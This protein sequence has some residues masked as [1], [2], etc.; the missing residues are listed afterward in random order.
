MDLGAAY[1]EGM[2]IPGR[3][4]NGVVVLEGGQSLPEGASV[5]VTVCNSEGS[6]EAKDLP[7]PFPIVRS[8][9]P[10]SVKLT[11]D[12]IAELLEDDDLSSGR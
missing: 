3:V 1:T 9:H 12:R 11:G 2:Q 5:V 8:K 10:G 4:S 7:L 6:Q